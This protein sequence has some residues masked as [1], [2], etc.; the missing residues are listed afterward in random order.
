M[1]LVTGGTGLLGS[2]VLFELCRSGMNVR[3]TYRNTG[4]LEQVRAVFRHYDPENGDR[5][6]E[7]IEWVEAD[8]TDIP[9]LDAAMKDVTTV[10][11]CAALVSFYRRDFYRL[12]KINREGTANVVNCALNA[13]VKK[14]IHVSS[15]AAIGSAPG[16][17]LTEAVK[18]KSGER[19]SGYAISKHGAEKEV[20]RGIEEGLPAAMVNPAMIIGAGNWNESSLTLFNTIRKG[21]RFVSPGANAFVDARDVAH[22]MILLA[23]SGIQGERF[24]MIGENISFREAFE[25]MAGAMGVKAPSIVPK[26]WM[27]NLAWRING[28]LAWILG[29]SPV[30]TR[31]TTRSAYRTTV[32]SAEKARRVLEMEFRDMD[33]MVSNAVA[34]RIH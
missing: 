30:I 5:L 21:L 24:L 32:Y 15:T 28:L 8:V 27:A 29:K 10:F 14:L 34:G 20:W 16:K 31:E 6:F 11:H 17:V 1:K 33:E 3:A 26:R 18:W 22:A 13:G 9:S 7:R 23:E 25:K 4:R 19:E 12:M 2:H